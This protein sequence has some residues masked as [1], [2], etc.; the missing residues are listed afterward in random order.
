MDILLLHEDEAVRDMVTFALEGKVH[1]VVHPVATAQAA[2]DLLLEENQIELIV[3][4]DSKENSRLYKYLLTVNSMILVILIRPKALQKIAV[5][6][7]L[8]VV[9]QV[10]PTQLP[11]GL[12]PLVH[13]A[14]KQGAG[15]NRNENPDYCRI[16]TNLLIKTGPLDADVFIKLS[17]IKFVRLFKKGDT[18]DQKDLERYFAAKRIEFL[19]IKNEECEVLVN[20]LSKSLSDILKA[21][22]ISAEESITLSEHVHE[23][24]MELSVRFGFTPQVQGLIKQNVETVLSGVQKVT[25]LKQIAAI[26][27]RG[28]S[29]YISSHSIMLA[30]I[31]GLFA[32]RTEWSSHTTLEK[33]T[34]AALLHDITLGDQRLA[35]VHSLE[36]LEDPAAGFS[37]EEKKKFIQHPNEAAELAMKFEKIP[38]DVWNIIREHHERPDGTGFPRSLIAARISPIST[39]F[40]IAHDVVSG[41]FKGERDLD[42]FLKNCVDQYRT[43]NFRKVVDAIIRK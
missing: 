40:I 42:G 9:G 4:T 1:A 38:A 31:A 6:P 20:Q 26:L 18:F 7:D 2:F 14:M 3:C 41:F 15:Y 37:K 8:K 29:G 21:G 23:T 17:N 39:L 30:H 12:I 16:K 19:Y 24:V 33:L 34:Y 22:E 32:T 5:F 43:G 25:G 36:E 13:Q 35:A 27:E 11:D 10:A 28:K